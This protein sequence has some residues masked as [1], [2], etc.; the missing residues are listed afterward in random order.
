M[1]QRHINRNSLVSLRSRW[2]YKAQTSQT[3]TP[4]I[5]EPYKTFACWAWPTD[6]LCAK[7][8]AL[9]CPW[10]DCFYLIAFVGDSSPGGEDLS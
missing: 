7:L 10:V 9:V 5:D 8:G 4:C 6:Q 1:L 2:V 3:I